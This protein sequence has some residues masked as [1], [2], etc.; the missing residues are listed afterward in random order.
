M[1]KYDAIHHDPP[2]PVAEVTLRDTDTGESLPGVRMLIDTGADITL[3]PAAA[4]AR[5]GVK[6]IPGYLREMEGFDGTK[7][8]APGALLDLV[9]L[10]RIYRGKY[11]L[12]DSECGILG[13]D[14]LAYH[15]PRIDGPDQ[16][17]SPILD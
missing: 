10:R 2:A 6:P 9:F 5:L 11:V 8:T 3:V 17:W 12:I 1:P 7:T 4:A 13:R 16:E 15:T 14:I